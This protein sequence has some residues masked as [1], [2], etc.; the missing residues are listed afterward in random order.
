[1]ED[2]FS[3]DDDSY[4]EIRVTTKTTR[5]KETQNKDK[6]IVEDQLDC[7]KEELSI[8][9]D[10]ENLDSYTKNDYMVMAFHFKAL[11]KV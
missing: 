3:Q 10:D 5:K 4:K 1:M 11:C 7:E 6:E 2:L 9:Y 8:D